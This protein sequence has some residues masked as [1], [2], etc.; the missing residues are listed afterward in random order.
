M[1]A[2]ARRGRATRGSARASQLLG[3][4][5]LAM[6]AVFATGR[7]FSITSSGSPPAPA[8]AHAVPATLGSCASPADLNALTSPSEGS[9]A[10]KQQGIAGLGAG[11]AYTAFAV[12]RI[13]LLEY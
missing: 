13:L 9:A 5:M 12:V 10:G 6:A 2:A 7:A 8:A 3:A 1:P 4:S 11:P